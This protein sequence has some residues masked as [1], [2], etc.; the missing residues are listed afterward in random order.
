[1]SWPPRPRT[2]SADLGLAASFPDPGAAQS[3]RHRRSLIVFLLVAALTLGGFTYLTNRYVNDPPRVLLVGDSV[4]LEATGAVAEQAP[5]SVRVAVLAGIGTSPCDLWVDG[6]RGH[7]QG[8]LPSLRT[9]L[10]QD[11]PT[12]VVFAFTGNPGVGDEACVA[13]SDG[14][15]PLSELIHSYRIA[16]DEMG[17]AANQMGA[18]V[19]LA[20][21]PPRNP[22]APEGWDGTTENNYNGDQ[23]INDMLYSLAST[24]GW[25]YDRT[26]AQ[27]L[28]SPSGAWTLYL[29]CQPADGIECVDGLA[30]V[31]EGG[32]DAIHCSRPRSDTVRSISSGSLRYAF[33]LLEQPLRFLGY[34]AA[35]LDTRPVSN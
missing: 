35:G 9:V 29:P 33:G 12:V 34:R 25:V 8:G 20:A 30:Q 16:L 1:M 17:T 32:S 27:Q 31:R 28:S 21:T 24:R 7:V 2:P 4:L 5:R 3:L 23:A 22:A 14:Y 18:R 19:Y 6:R 10:Y 15:Y 11:R 13:G 26:A